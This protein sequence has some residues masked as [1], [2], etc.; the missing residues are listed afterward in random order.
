[1]PNATNFLFDIGMESP[2]YII[3][4]FEN[5][6]VNEQTHDASTFDIMK[7][8]ECCCM[9]GSEFYPE[10]TMN[11]NYGTKNYNEAFKEIVI[12]NKDYNG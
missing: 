10:D 6:Y 1:M 5:N 3:I 2:Q 4:S 9:I 11:I 12:F 7:V 8:T